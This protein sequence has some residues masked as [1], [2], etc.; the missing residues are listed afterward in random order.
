[1]QLEETNLVTWKLILLLIFGRSKYDYTMC[2]KW[3]RSGFS[4]PHF[5]AEHL[6]DILTC[7]F[8][9]FVNVQTN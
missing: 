6:P 4:W 8:L 3:I 1:L 7:N 2:S 9:L 5:A